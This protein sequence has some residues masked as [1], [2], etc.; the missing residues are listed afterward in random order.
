M[1]WSH[2]SA[3]QYRDQRGILRVLSVER[4]TGM[5]IKRVFWVSDVAP[6]ETRGQHAHKSGHQVLICLSGSL[7][8]TL[9]DHLGEETIVLSPNSPAIWM[10]PLTWGVQ[11]FLQPETVLLVLASNEFDESD[12]IRDE[13]EFR[14]LV[15]KRS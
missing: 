7:E 8:V 3:E 14:S 2:I 4:E 1:P 12:Y 15:Q 10:K 9:R 5:S 11:R 13:Q 6:G